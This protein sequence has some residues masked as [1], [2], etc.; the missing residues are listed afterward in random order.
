VLTLSKAR[1]TIGY[2]AA[3][4]CA[5]VAVS[6]KRQG[7]RAAND[8]GIS[9]DSLRGD[10]TAALPVFREWTLTAGRHLLVA[11]AAP[12]TAIAVFPEFTVDT[13]LASVQFVPGAGTLVEYDLFASDGSATRA[14]LTSVT[15]P[16]RGCETWPVAHFAP[17]TELRP[18]TV[19]LQAG[20]ARGIAYLPLDQLPAPDSARTVVDLARLASQA[21][22]DTTAALRGLPYVVRSAYV[23]A[24][25]D[26]QSFVFG[27][28]VRRLNIEA[29]PH[30]ERTT[31]IGERGGTAGPYTLAFSERHAGDEESVPT[32]ELIGLVQLRDGRYVTFGARDFSDGGTYVM[33]E[34]SKGPRW[35]VRWQSAY[36]GC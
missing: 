18:W 19:G 5:V 29:S 21:P 1:L 10:T 7:D 25:A 31:V 15:G 24:L 36:A 28:L 8:S 13:T 27:E 32:T 12:D 35:R 26:S 11:T 34:R 16:R 33:L 6:C 17:S 20:H 14:R 22:N 30:E 9:R 23:A 3:M 2:V 4:L